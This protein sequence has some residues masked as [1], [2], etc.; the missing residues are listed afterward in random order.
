MEIG[1]QSR[2]R[3]GRRRIIIFGVLL[4]WVSPVVRG[5]VPE[6]LFFAIGT[7]QTNCFFLPDTSNLTAWRKQRG[8]IDLQW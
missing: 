4:L 2:W 1:G 5:F 7:G 3:V 8:L 6:M